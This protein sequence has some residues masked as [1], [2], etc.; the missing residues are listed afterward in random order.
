MLKVGIVGFG[1]MGRMH[2]RCW[3]RRQDSRVVAVC[4]TNPDVRANT[5]DR[6]GNIEGASGR[7]EFEGIG[8]FSSLDE[9]LQSVEL[10]AV[11]LTVPTHLH[12]EYA[13][14]ILSKGIHVLCEKPMALGVDDCDLMIEAAGRSGKQLQVG[15]CLRFWPEYA[16]AKEFVADGR[17]GKVVAATFQRLGSAPSWGQNDWFLDEARSGGVALDLHIHDTDFIQHLFGMPEAVSSQGVAQ[18]GRLRHIVTQY[19]YDD[20]KVVTAEGSWAMSPSFGF[21]MSFNLAF[22]KA[23][24]VYDLTRQPAF[25][26]C[27]A[28]GEVFVPEVADGDG[29]MR[30][31]AHFADVINGGKVDE[32]ITAQQSRQSVKIVQ[33]EKESIRT[34]HPVEIE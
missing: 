5:A 6:V 29:Y 12:A 22:E 24:V 1:F 4:D 16:K 25:R 7:L 13:V 9:M 26:V 31:I 33:A 8:F 2:L 32:V 23:T 11:S 19:L 17:Y 30:Q 34:H 21:E 15:H 10:D 28:Q 20:D 3:S 27:P 14:S 18:D